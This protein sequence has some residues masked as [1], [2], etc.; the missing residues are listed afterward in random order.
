MTLSYYIT[1]TVG[2]LLKF[3]TNLNWEHSGKKIKFFTVQNLGEKQNEPTIGRYGRFYDIQ[4][5]WRHS[6]ETG[7]V[8]K[9]YCSYYALYKNLYNGSTIDDCRTEAINVKSR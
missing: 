4:V 7:V 1:P 9:W 3:L 8:L 5:E 6:K 2:L